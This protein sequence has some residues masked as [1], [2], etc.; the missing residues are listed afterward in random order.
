LSTKIEIEDLTIPPPDID[1]SK[2]TEEVKVRMPE[3]GDGQGKVVAWYKTEGDIVRHGDVLC[4]I[5]TADFTF[6]M[7]T[8]DEGLGIMG[9]ILVEAPSD[10][11]KDGEVICILLHESK[12]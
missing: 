6:G 2:Y 11:I 3:M 7:E 1:R 4:D 5:E 12:E 10:M 8:D 9:P